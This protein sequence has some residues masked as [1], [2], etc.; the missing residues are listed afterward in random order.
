M[1]D[2]P[3]GTALAHIVRERMR[4]LVRDAARAL[5]RGRNDEL[6]ALRIDVK[7]LRYNLEFLVPLAREQTLA[8]LDLLAV[9]QERLG[10]LADADTFAR[11][12]DGMRADVPAGDPR[13]PGL[14]TL[15]A[16]AERERE[17]SLAAVRA[18]WRGDNATYPERLAASI[19]ATLA[20]VSAKAAPYAGRGTTSNETVV[21]KARSNRSDL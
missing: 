15:R 14:A 4:A 7:R 19:S 1:R 2:T 12:Y 5:R 11:T 18:L 13:E 10:A 8:A 9:L 17:R 3:F 21:A 6:H 20:S 16:N